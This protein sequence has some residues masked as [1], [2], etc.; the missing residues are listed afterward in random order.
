MRTLPYVLI[1]F[2]TALLMAGFAQMPLGTPPTVWTV[3]LLL[4]GALILTAGCVLYWHWY[5]RRPLLQAW[6]G[7]PRTIVPPARRR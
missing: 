5:E 6:D 2:G 7:P 3:V 4:I 1:T